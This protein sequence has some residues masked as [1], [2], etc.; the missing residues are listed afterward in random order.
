MLCEAPKYLLD[1][2][3]CDV[4]IDVFLKTGGL[5][6]RERRASFLVKSFELCIVQELQFL[7]PKMSPNG[8]NSN[9]VGVR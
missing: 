7:P 4:M 6:A 5:F 9:T 2:D 8:Q 1:I 3:G